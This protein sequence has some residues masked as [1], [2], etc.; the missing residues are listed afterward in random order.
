MAPRLTNYCGIFSR[1]PTLLC[2]NKLITKSQREL[3]KINQKSVW[4]GRE[5]R[6]GFQLHKAEAFDSWRWDRS[7]LFFHLC[8]SFPLLELFFSDLS[9][10]AISFLPS[11]GVNDPGGLAGCE[12]KLVN[13]GL[14]R[15]RGGGVQDITLNFR[16]HAAPVCVCSCVWTPAGGC[17]HRLAWHR[18][19][20]Q[21]LPGKWGGNDC[22]NSVLKTD[23]ESDFGELTTTLTKDRLSFSL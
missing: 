5:E 13:Q 18:S 11:A 4:E 9:L 20:F 8:Y 7:P 1:G 2:R 19:R 14:R 3:P 6:R 12:Q 16:L 21:R 22:A 23:R 15:G 17:Q 10:F